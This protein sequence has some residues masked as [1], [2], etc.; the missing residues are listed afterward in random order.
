MNVET[1]I[2]KLNEDCESAVESWLILEKAFLPKDKAHYLQ[3]YSDFMECRLDNNESIGVYAARI[4]RLNKEL[5]KLDQ[6]LED[7]CM[8]F[9]II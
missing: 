3:V 6:N 9:Q 5:Q 8:V 4:S 2:R 1:D 7:K